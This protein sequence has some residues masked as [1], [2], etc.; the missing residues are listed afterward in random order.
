M[1][2]QLKSVLIAATVLAAFLGLGATS[3]A[4][5]TG[6]PH[7]LSLDNPRGHCINCHDLHQTGL[8]EGYEHNLKRANEIEVCYQCHA[9][10]MSDYSSI[11]PSFPNH[12]ELLSGY[13]I[14]AEFSDTH[15]HFERYGMDGEHNKCSHCHN[16]HGVFDPTS[17]MRLP[18][19]LSAGPDAVTATDEF[20]FVCHNSDASPPHSPFANI[21]LGAEYKFSRTGY[22]DM[23]HSTFYRADTLTEPV[24]DTAKTYD[25]NPY[26]AGKDI[27]CLSC[28]RPHGSPNDHMLKSADDQSFCLACHD[29][30]KA[31]DLTQFTVTGHGKPGAGRICQECHFPHGTGQENAVK[32]AIT[33]PHTGTD[34]AANVN[35]LG[36][37]EACYA[38][39]GGTSTTLYSNAFPANVS[40]WYSSGPTTTWAGTA[41]HTAMGSMKQVTTYAGDCYSYTNEIAVQPGKGYT[42]SG[43]VYLPQTLTG[44]GVRLRVIE[45]NS[46]GG[47]VSDKSPASTTTTAG[48]WMYKKFTITTEANTAKV[49]LRLNIN[50][51]GTVYWDDLV[52]GESLYPGGYFTGKASYTASVHATSP[53]AHNPTDTTGDQQP[54][55]CDN[56]HDPHGKGNTAMLLKPG[57]QLCY[58]CHNAVTPNTQSGDDVKAAFQM[59]SNHDLTKAGCTDCHNVH[60]ATQNSVMMDPYNPAG[61]V[62]NANQFCLSCHSGIMPDG[63]TGAPGVSAHWTGGGHDKTHVLVC[64]DCHEPHG[65]P[66]QKNLNYRPLTSGAYTAQFSSGMSFAARAFCESCHNR[67][68]AGFKGAAKIPTGEGYVSQHAQGDAESCSTCHAQGHDPKLSNYTGSSSFYTVACLECHTS[69]AG[70]PYP[71]PDSEFNTPA[72]VSDTDTRKS[73]HNVTYKPYSTVP[74]VNCVSCHGKDHENNHSATVKVIDPDTFNGVSGL[75]PAVSVSSVFCLECH[76]STPVSMGG[77]TPPDIMATYTTGGHGKQGAGVICSVCHGY[78]GAASEKLL[79][80]TING[81][82][83]LGTY[84]GNN[85]SVCTACHSATD[86]ALPKWPGFGVYSGSIHAFGNDTTGNYATDGRHGPGVCANCHNPHGSKVDGG[87]THSM[88]RKDG[89]DLCYSCHSSGFDNFSSTGGYN[90]KWNR[91]ASTVLAV[92]KQ[93]GRL[94]YG[95]T[96]ISAGVNVDD[97][98]ESSASFRDED[99]TVT[100][101]LK[102]TEMTRTDGGAR[103]GVHIYDPIQTSRYVLLFHR[104]STAPRAWLARYTNDG[105]TGT[106]LDAIGDESANYHTLKLVRRKSAGEVDAYLDNTLVRT[107]QFT[108]SGHFKVRLY[109]SVNSTADATPEAVELSW[110]DFS[111][112]YANGVTPYNTASGDDVQARFNMKSRH[113]LSDADQLGPDGLPGTA[114]DSRVECADC[115]DPHTVT[116]KLMAYRNVSGVIV[117][118]EADQEFCLKCH[119]GDP[120]AGVVFPSDGVWDKSGYGSSAHGNPLKR[121][122]TFGNYSNGVIYACKVCHNPHGSDQASLQRES[123]DIDRDGIPD[124]IDGDGVLDSATLV[125]FIGYSSGSRKVIVVDSPRPG[126]QR[127]S[128]TVPYQ[129][130]GSIDVELCFNCHDG[131]PAPDVETDF[132]K[133]SHHDVTYEEQ[134]ASG[135]SKIECYNCHDQHRAQARDAGAGDYPATNPDPPREP[136]PGDAQFCLACHDNTL[137]EGVS[138]GASQPKNVKLSYNPYDL[139][140]ADGYDL[141]TSY[142]GHYVQSTGAPLMCRECHNQHGSDYDKMLRDDTESAAPSHDPSQPVQE[143]QRIALRSTDEFSGGDDIPL[144]STTERCLTCHS[145]KT[146]FNG[147]LLPLPPPPDAVERGFSMPPVAKHPDLKPDVTSADETGG[148]IYKPVFAVV[149]TPGSVKKD[150]TFCHDSHNPFIATVSG[151]LMDCYQCHN[152]NTALPDVQSEFNDNPTN[153]ARSQSIHPVHYDP[154]GTD[155]YAVECLKCHDQSRHMRGVVRLRKDPGSFDNFTSD[156]DVWADPVASRTINQFCLECHGPSSTGTSFYKGGTEHVPPKLPAGYASGAHF[157]D[158]SLQCTACHEYHGSVNKGLRKN[159]FGGEESFCYGCHAN[160]ANSMG[161]V[162]IQAK[163]AQPNRHNVDSSSQTATSSKVECESCHNPHVVTRTAPVVSADDSSVAVASDALFCTGCHDSSGAP[164][165]KFPGIATGTNGPE[166]NLATGGWNRW[167]KQAYDGSTHDM[168]GVGCTGCHDPHGS[169]NYSMLLQNISSSTGIAVG[170]GVHSTARGK[171]TEELGVNSVC[172]SCHQGQTGVYD[173]YAGFTSLTFG[174]KAGIDKNCTYCH[175]PHGTTQPGLIRSDKPLNMDMSSAGFGSVY[176]FK[177]FGNHTTGAPYYTFCSSRNCHASE[178]D[179]AV[180]DTFNMDLPVD[181]FTRDETKSSHHPIKEGVVGCTSCHKEHGSA[182]SPDLRAPFYRESNWPELFH[183]GRGVYSTYHRPG[184]GTPFDGSNFFELSPYPPS[185]P[186]DATHRNRVTTVNPPSNAND[187]CF[188][189]HQKD[190]VT[191][192]AASGMTGANTRFLGHEAVKGGAVISH[193]IARD[194]N[195]TGVDFHNFSCSTCHFPHSSTR[196]KLLKVG[197]FS[198]SDNQYVGVG[199]SSYTSTIFQCHAYTKWSNYN[200]GWRN[201]TTVKTDFK[202]P[203]SVVTDLAYSVDADLTVHLSWTAVNDAPGQGADHYNVYRYTQPVTQDSKPYATR[204]VKGVAGQSAGLPVSWADNTGQPSTTYYYAVVA[205]DA[206]NNESFISNCVTVPLGADVVTPDAIANQQVMQVGGTYNAKVTWRDPGDNINAASYKVYRVNGLTPLTDTDISPANYLATVTDSSQSA[207]GSPDAV[208]YSYTDATT[209][210]GNDYSFAAVAVDA[211]G[212]V[213]HVPTGAVFSISITDPPP[214]E[215][216]TLTVKPVSVAMGALLTWTAPINIGA[217]SGYNVY[218]KAGS[219][220]TQTDIVPGNLLQGPVAGLTYTDSNVPATAADYYYAVTAVDESSG[221]ESAI[222]NSL[223]VNIPAPPTGLTAVKLLNSDVKL[224]WS[225][226]VFTTGF[227]NYKVYRRRET[228]AWTSVTTTASTTATLDLTG[229]EPGMYEFAVT[230]NYTTYGGTTPYESVRSASA[231]LNFADTVAPSSFTVSGALTQASNYTVARVIWDAPADQNFSGYTPAG[232]DYYKVDAT[233][234]QGVMWATVISSRLANP[235][236]ETHAGTVDDIY[237]DS[238]TDWTVSATSAFAVSDSLFDSRAIKIRYNGSGDRY[239]VSAEPSTGQTIAGKTYS[240]SFWAKASKDTTFQYFIQTSTGTSESIGVVSPAIGTGWQRF[241]TSG[242][243]SAAPTATAARVVIRPSSDTT[244]EITIDGVR[245]EPNTAALTANDG[246]YFRPAGYETPGSAQSFDDIKPLTAGTSAKYR[247]SAVDTSGNFSA[248]ASTG[249]VYA[250]P[251]VITDLKVA[252]STSTSANVLTFSP[253]VSLAGLSAYNIYAREQAAPLTDTTG[254]TLIDTMT[255]NVASGN[256]ALTATASASNT[257]SIYVAAN[258]KDGNTATRWDGLHNV[259]ANWLKLDFGKQVML[260]GVSFDLFNSTYYRP[261][262]FQVQTYNGTSWT[263]QRTVTGNTNNT[264]SYTFDPPVK[265]NQVRIYITKTYDTTMTYRP[266]INEFRAYAVDQYVHDLQNQTM[267]AETGHTYAYAVIAQDVSGLVSDLSGGSPTVNAVLDKDAP[268]RVEDL[269]LS[270]PIG[271][272]QVVLS[273]ST[274]IDNLGYGTGSGAVSYKIYRLPTSSIGTPAPVTD[275]N[276]GT[277]SL[278]YTG[279]YASSQAGTPNSYTATWYDHKGVY[280]AISSADAAGNWSSISNSPFITVGKDV[281]AP[282]PPYITNCVPVATP[283]VDVYWSPAIDNVGI[284]GYRM[285]R[286]DVDVEPF[287]TDRCITENNVDLAEVAVSLIPYNA[288]EA[289]DTGGVPG[290]TY[291]FALRAWDDAGNLSNISNCAVATVRTTSTDTTAP[292][293]PP[294]P[295]S[296]QQQPYPDIDLFW[297]AATDQDNSGGNGTIDHYDIYRSLSAFSSV[298]DPGVTK[299]STV[300]SVRHSYIDRTGNHDTTYYYG[301]V[302]VDASVG[303]NASALSNVGSAAV[304]TAPSP[305]NVPPSVP[306]DIAAATGVYPYINLSWS[307]SSDVDDAASP[308]QLL[309]YKLY[310]SDYPLDITDANKDNQSLVNTY[311]MANDAVSYVARGVGDMLYNYRLEAF[312]IAGNPSGMGGQVTGRVASAPCVDAT[313]PTA[314]SGLAATVGPSPDLDLSWAAS[315]DNLGSCNG[316]ID[317]Y[318]M[319]KADFEITAST[320]LRTLPHTHVSGNSTSYVDSSGEPNKVYWYVMTAVDSSGNESGKS[321]II[322]KTTAADTMAPA[323][324][325]DL[326]ATPGAGSALLTWCKPSDNVG[327]DH[328]EIYRKEQSSIL[329]DSDMVSGNRIALFVNAGTCLSY[330]DSGVSSGHTYSYAVISV[331]GAGNRSTISR[332][333]ASGDTIAVMP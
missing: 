272:T 157:T 2:G 169:P 220:L 291:Y 306:G 276:Y 307:A 323:A 305:D 244:A 53:A 149:T 119:D 52:F 11:D 6:R 236:F 314:P 259:G 262:D 286:A 96:A 209:Q 109:C 123:W 17:T 250:K 170:F 104:A 218:R 85:V 317:H 5:V 57:E 181:N 140:D 73:I 151:Q 93:G 212:S 196:G 37:K 138:F 208:T 293:W 311:I 201:L 186:P 36:M 13:D 183:A 89:E 309:Y 269:S 217:I 240:M 45:Y 19:L 327:I 239:I 175:N 121:N 60:S 135:G 106:T 131:S 3:R 231:S 184:V 275:D 205:C 199:G 295:L 27:S 34:N 254:A 198:Q 61:V 166:W 246:S 144:S 242:T 115:H 22:R 21:S 190:D 16:P 222:G 268:A 55:D 86:A 243:F 292:M 39:H 23:T 47:V 120:P 9:G 271:G 216:T 210:F 125:G 319:Y 112:S 203:P 255:P 83:V 161:G 261:A 51:I 14:R 330:T 146:T 62:T 113:N 280:Y 95:R 98:V 274:P 182:N 105:G 206:E 124:D 77:M 42:F 66:N 265:T 78:H 65:S 152:E 328:Y 64:T 72:N 75:M 111:V 114:D 134:Q 320:D 153:P 63:V 302:A 213:A 257:Y 256:I 179:P 297:Q 248:A 172:R 82:P 232:L 1:Q 139:R 214:S 67:T 226:P 290:K 251:S 180:I 50:S 12:S 234:N 289:A 7:D 278:V 219:A 143:M 324:V 54:G 249:Y 90:D 108:S 283:E 223:A 48:M 165:V 150:C 69:G 59:V 128:S 70:N 224:V 100:V 84:S 294:T 189:C 315:L 91:Y 56:C 252:S 264:P 162:N 308:R 173:G 281:D 74:T 194:I 228:G 99:C 160:P 103:F 133:R 321:G 44:T 46:S 329:T 117:P 35:G 29:G 284:N 267:K 8:G 28:H 118:I 318:N 204:V 158:G 79:K 31:P 154:T 207:D 227:V 266:I 4:D 68:G 41:G 282:V 107:C 168:Q 164:G 20:C 147:Q 80:G 81:Q 299:L 148:H 159:E 185:W 25:D 301:I 187:L 87:L 332:G 279:T 304:A 88:A 192:T 312:D 97:G 263:T 193:D 176:N 10:S 245:L 177:G 102:V 285:F 253:S 127:I 296:V 49:R 215:V 200:A 174:H 288:V 122:R 322:T 101:R 167:D 156:S 163:F 277:A 191:G 300:S 132:S 225:P 110:D 235:G 171:R 33:D 145:G 326:K 310:R 188:M 94:H 229:L 116:E 233:F 130:N 287:L 141:I 129:E 303:A 195:G 202:R 241:T 142:N 71:Y 273:W 76:D 155:S 137:P 247:V 316:V 58:D 24:P 15:S 92:A 18:K 43:Y 298:T 237:A 230:A 313:V 30:S 197:C 260:S 238:F 258:A 136:M 178:R 38:C 331:D 333:E 32:T 211:A 40:N 221:K 270:S 325:A 26:G 126:F